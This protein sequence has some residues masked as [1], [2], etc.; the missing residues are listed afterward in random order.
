M[1]TSSTFIS[2]YA[3]SSENICL[4]STISMILIFLFVVS[5]LNQ[6]LM[7]SFIG[8]LLVL[9]FLVYIL[10]YNVTL[11]NKFSTKL[12]IQLAN[13]DWSPIKTNI[14]CSYIFSFCIFILVLSIVRTLFR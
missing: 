13:G 3:K 2:E 6:F 14:I 4:Y 10:F 12:Q 11:T 5:P 9:V 7:T 8:K 1:N